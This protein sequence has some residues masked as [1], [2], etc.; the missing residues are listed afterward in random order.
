MILVKNRPNRTRYCKSIQEMS[1]L[2]TLGSGELIT[3]Q[4]VKFMTQE[5]PLRMH[6]LSMVTMLLPMDSLLSILYRHQSTGGVIMEK[7]ISSSQN[8]PTMLLKNNSMINMAIKQI[9]K[10]RTIKDGAWEFTH[11]SVTMMLLS[12]VALKLQLVL[13]FNLQTFYQ[14]FSMVK[15][16]LLMS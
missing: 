4:A 9:R 13:I 3:M 7:P 15:V 5:I 14:S 16:A 11:F 6:Q 12:K 1:S 8:F 2:T 10:L